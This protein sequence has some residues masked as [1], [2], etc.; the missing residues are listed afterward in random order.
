MEQAKLYAESKRLNVSF[1][2]ATNGHQ[3][4]FFDR[5][6]GITSKPRPIAEIP[7]TAEL[8]AAYESGMGNARDFTA[9][10]LINI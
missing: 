6:T 5:I 1:V 2:I 8:R 10:K 4:V 9:H 7:T 3:F